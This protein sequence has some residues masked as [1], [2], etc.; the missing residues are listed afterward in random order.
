MAVSTAKDGKKSIPG[1][2]G[3][4]SV[5]G[6]Q[7][8]DRALS[9]LLQIAASPPPGLSLAECSSILGY[10][11]PT[12]QRLLRTL[13]RR[14]FLHYD[15]DL[16]VYSL[17]V[18]NARLGSTYLN[19]VTLRQAA[20]A[21]MRRLVVETRETAHLGIL[22][23][24]NVV[25]IDVADSPQPVRIFSRVGD[26]VPAYATAVGKA[27]LAFLP[28]ADLREHLPGT[29]AARTPNT[30]V[31]IPDLLAD[32]ERTRQRGYSIDD[33]EN[34]EGIRGFAA[35]VFDAE[36]KVC[37][38]VSIAGPESRVSPESAERYGPLIRE[39]AAEISALLGAP[40]GG[41]PAAAG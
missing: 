4:D 30:I 16:G 21:A 33:A 28:P 40:A 8:L 22:S 32:F 15:E 3:G 12:T 38:A 17:G 37:G 5:S 39:T 1:A 20:L 13:T 34:R 41:G 35:P 27:I 11:K 10:S 18:A 14:E 9:V 31:T 19:R 2:S 7:G 29:L 24:S 6:T 25:Y 26:A 36:N 23:G